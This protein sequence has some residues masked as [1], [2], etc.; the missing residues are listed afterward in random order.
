MLRVAANHEQLLAPANDAALG[1]HGF[2]TRADFHCSLFTIGDTTFLQV[3]GGHFQNH[4]VA[5]Q[6]FNAVHTHAARKVGVHHVL[7]LELHAEGG[8]REELLHNPFHFQEAFL[9]DAPGFWLRAVGLRLWHA[10]V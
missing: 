2:D 4:C 1:A 7:V 10:N 5:R 8:R 9:I 3:V 6:D